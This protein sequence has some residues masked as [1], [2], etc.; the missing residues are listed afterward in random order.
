MATELLAVFS[1]CDHADSWTTLTRDRING[2]ATAN[3]DLDLGTYAL[4]D[5]FHITAYQ[6]AHRAFLSGQVLGGPP[7]ADNVLIN[8]V[9]TVCGGAF[10]VTR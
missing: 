1:Q 7:Q 3:Y 9:R 8:G 2:P 6:A 4:T 10:V 5:W